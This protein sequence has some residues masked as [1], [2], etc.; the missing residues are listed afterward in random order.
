MAVKATKDS[1]KNKKASVKRS[2]GEITAKRE[3]DKSGKF[4]KGNTTGGRKALPPDI[5][6]M[7]YKATP[8][9]C[10]LLCKVINDENEEMKL[11]IKASEIVLDRIYGKPA[12]AV[13]LNA[14]SLPQVVFVG[15]DSIAD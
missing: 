10:K 2:N 3:R 1:K 12:Q 9:A 11:R 5:K 8:A 14:G 13:D 6:D 4:V 7:L 15:G